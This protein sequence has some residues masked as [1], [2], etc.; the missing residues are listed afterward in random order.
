MFASIQQNRINSAVL[1]AY[2]IRTLMMPQWFVPENNCWLWPHVL[3]I[4][5]STW[6]TV[7][8]LPFSPASSSP[9]Q[10]SVPALQCCHSSPW[11]LMPLFCLWAGTGSSSPCPAAPCFLS[12]SF[13]SE[14]STSPA[15]L[16]VL[17]SATLSFAPSSCLQCLSPGWLTAPW[18]LECDAIL[19]AK[20]YNKAHYEF[21]VV[22]FCQPQTKSKKNAVFPYIMKSIC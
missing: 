22:G 12:D 10:P 14:H 1:F 5:P 20:S 16:G 6:W 11:H 3:T 8:P 19:P 15:P 9:T 7:S 18:H 13:P 4:W 17:G 21:K 2:L